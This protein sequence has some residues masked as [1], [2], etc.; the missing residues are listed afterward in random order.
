[1]R[2]LCYRPL[3]HQ[4]ESKDSYNNGSYVNKEETNTLIHNKVIA[5]CRSIY[6]IRCCDISKSYPLTDHNRIAPDA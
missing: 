5:S 6:T 4:P 1:M 3:W 2:P